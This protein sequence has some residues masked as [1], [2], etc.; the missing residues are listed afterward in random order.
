M[1]D[2]NL[3][4]FLG[5]T[6]VDVPVAAGLPG[7]VYRRAQGMDEGVHVT[8]V[9]VVL[10]VP[11]GGGQHDVGV[12]AGGAHA[13]V[14]RD[15]QVKLALGRLVVPHHLFRL[16]ITGAQV[17]ALHAVAGT[18]Q[19]FEE[20]LVALAAGAQDVGAP[21]E[22][23]ARPV[24]GVVRVFAA[25][26]LAAVL[27]AFDQVVLGLHVGCHRVPNQLHRVGLELGRRGQPAHAFSTHVVVD[28][29]AAKLGLV[30][31]GTQ[32]FIDAQ[33]FIAPLVGVGVE[34]AGGVHLPGRTDPVQCKGQRRPAGLRA[35]FFLAYIVRP[36]ATRLA[37][38]AAHHQHV[39]D[40]AVVHV[41]VVPVV[42][43]C[44][45]DHHGLAMGLVGVFG[46]LARHGDELLTRRAGDALLPG[47]CVRG[48]VVE[49]LCSQF[50]D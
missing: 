35:Q 50:T 1:A 20:V 41:S 48:V 28:H 16:G 31:Q 43:G 11:G 5:E 15:Q 19:V 49:V 4:E 9:E 10:L 21:D 45:D 24:V 17:L 6:L 30:G 13:E 29:A 3:A 47:R 32:H 2:A 22:H 44:A 27:Q 33:F 7:R 14:Q 8:G 42:H 18:E 40:A 25:H 36:T 37:D 38:T 34:K 46:K 26:G 23:V 39:D 12:Q